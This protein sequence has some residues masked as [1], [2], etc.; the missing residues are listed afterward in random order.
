MLLAAA[1]AAA[2]VAAT[3]AAALNGDD[4]MDDIPDVS[5]SPLNLEFFRPIN[6]LLPPVQ[7]C[8]TP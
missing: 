2:A 4:C 7:Q 1:A 5:T 8:S 6:H 3:A